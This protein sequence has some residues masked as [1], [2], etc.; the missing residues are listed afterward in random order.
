MLL[1]RLT[2]TQEK[3]SAAT[4]RNTTK[5]YEAYQAELVLHTGLRLVGTIHLL[6]IVRLLMCRHEK[7]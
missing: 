2:C 3:G 4:K 5:S 7:R 6:K 1:L